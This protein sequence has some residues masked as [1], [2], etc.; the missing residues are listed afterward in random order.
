[1]NESVQNDPFPSFSK[2]FVEDVEA[3]LSEN[4]PGEIP[5]IPWEA[6]LQLKPILIKHKEDADLVRKYINKGDARLLND[7]ATKAKALRASFV[8]AAESEL[9]GYLAVVFR[10]IEIEEI[11]AG[12]EG[13]SELV[14]IDF[15]AQ[16][17]PDDHTRAILYSE[18]EQWW[19]TNTNT[20]ASIQEGSEDAPPTPFMFVLSKI[21]WLA[22]MPAPK[23]G[24][25]F[26]TIKKH[27]KQA[28]KHAQKEE[29]RRQNLIRLAERL[30]SLPASKLFD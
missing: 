18:I 17:L 21:S 5:T 16:T 14:S 10:P 2:A 24:T 9:D 11:K 25:S 4:F 13:I 15:D 20:A 8:R 1:M 26:A 29:E 6:W 7:I 12:L 19:K 3:G 22:D 30:E 28:K 23:L 27:R